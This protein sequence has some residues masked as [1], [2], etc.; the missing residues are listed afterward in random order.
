[1]KRV[2][3]FVVVMLIGTTSNIAL[4]ADQTELAKDLMQVLG[5]DSMLESVRKDTIKMVEGQMDGIIAQLRNSNP[6]ISDSTLKE[7]KAAA[8]E[9]GHRITNSWN[10]AEAARIYSASLVDGLPES[11]MRAAIEH[12]KTPEGQRELK[13]IN[14]AVKKTNSYIMG[15][16]QKETEL[17]M[18]D[19][20][21]EIRS[22][23]ERAR[24]SKSDR[25]PSI[26]IDRKGQ[27]SGAN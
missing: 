22:I 3:M 8:Q 12:Y 6:N 13:V 23:A 5:F 21:G 17:A 2:M 14:D 16:I 26:G 20:L 24:A 15:S 18:K 19:F 4:A 7:F 25:S 9:F 27:R 11:D 10:S 1:M